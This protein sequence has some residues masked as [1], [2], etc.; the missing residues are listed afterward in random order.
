[1]GSIVGLLTSPAI[2][3]AFGWPTLF[4]LF[5]A[6]GAVW[7]VWFENLMREIE[8]RDPELAAKLRPAVETMPLGRS[9]A[10]LDRSATTLA[11]SATMV[12][13]LAPTSTLGNNPAAAAAANSA[14][15]SVQPHASPE[16]TAHH[17]H[18]SHGHGGAL[19]GAG[20][21]YRAFLRSAPVRA[22]AFTHFAHNWFHFTMLS[23]LPTYF[24]S[25]LS[26]D[27]MHAAQTALLPP[28]A[29]IVASTIAGTAGGAVGD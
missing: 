23:W 2:I 6:L 1:M 12:A 11:P 17:A 26:V 15:T 7:L 13:P 24:T 3:S 27:L 19:V 14:A 25:T 28:M 8:D 16:E 21:P 29:G 4:Y 10:V 22:L 18:G 9:A 5:G 20:I